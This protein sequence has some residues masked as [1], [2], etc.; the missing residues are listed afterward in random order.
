MSQ[1]G[2]PSEVSFQEI[3]RKTTLGKAIELCAEAAGLEPKQIQERLKTDKGQWS[4]WISGGEGIVWEKFEA[5]MDECGNDAPILWMLHRRG[6][7][8][9]SLR[10]KE[11]ELE[12]ELRIAREEINQLKHDKRVLAEAFAARA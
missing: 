9:A 6:Y 4:R 5:L 1:L 7:D 12:R 11:T 10:R 2:F 3:E 8:L